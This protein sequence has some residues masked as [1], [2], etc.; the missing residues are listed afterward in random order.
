MT[1]AAGSQNIN[2]G[3]GN[4]TISGD[5]GSDVLDG[6]SGTN[7]VTYSFEPST[8]PVGIDLTA[9]TATAPDGTST[10]NN[11]QN[12]V[13]G[14]GDDTLRGT[15]G[16][17]T[18]QGGDG[19]DTI[20]GLGG[21]DTIDGQG[22]TNTV[23]YADEP[24][25]PG[26]TVDLS[27]GTA[28]T[29][30]GGTD[31]LSN[32]E[33]IRGGPA[34]DT[35]KMPATGTA[36]VDMG[37]GTNTLDFSAQAAGAKFNYSTPTTVVV[38]GQTF[39]DVEKLIGT[40]GDDTINGDSGNQDIN[41]GPGDDTI[42]GGG[43]SDTLDG[44]TGTN[45]VSFAF[46]FTSVVLDLGSG[47]SA[48]N[49]GIC[50]LANF[51]N[52]I[53]GAGD[54]L[55]QG[56]AGANTLDGG[57]GNDTIQG[58]GGGDTINGQGGSDTV[59]Y[60]DEPAG[61]GVVVDLAAGTAN[62][63]DGATDKL[64]NVE[65]ILGGP[66]DDTVKMAASGNAGVD[67][68]GGTNTLDFTA[69]RSGSTFDFT[70]PTT[71]TIGSQTFPN[72]QKL[73]GSSAN[74]TF[75][76]A[77][78]TDPLDGGGGVN[79]L[80]YASLA[81]GQDVTVDLQAGTALTPLGQTSITNFQNATGGGGNDELLGTVG[82][83][84]LIGG[85]GD[86]TLDGRA[87][88][89]YLDGGT[90]NDTLR[91]G[92]GKD[93]ILGGAGNDTVT[94]DDRSAPVTI[95]LDAQPDSGESGE[96]DL[97][98]GVENAIGGSGDDTIVGNAGNNDLQGGDGNDTLIGGLGDDTLD[99][100]AGND[101]ASYADRGDND[102]VTVDLA[103]G[104]GGERG[105]HDQLVSIEGAIGGDAADTLNGGPGNDTLDGGA[106]DDTITGG[107]GNDTI[108][109]GAGN[110]FIDGGP[111]ADTVTGG[112]GDDVVEAA[113]GTADTVDCGDGKDVV[114]ADT[115]DIISNCETIHLPQGSLGGAPPPVLPTDADGDGYSPPQDCN[116]HNPN[117]HPG[118]YDIPGDG[119]DQNCDGHD[120]QFPPISA[121]LKARFSSARHGW[122]RVR[123]LSVKHAAANTDIEVSC[124]SSHFNACP[125]RDE[126]QVLAHQTPFYSLR[127][128]FG[129]VPVRPGTK[130]VLKLVQPGAIGRIYTYLFRQGSFPKLSLLCQA[131][132]KPV[133]RC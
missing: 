12:A 129:D 92:T 109:G 26:V 91:G 102:P 9:G 28:K 38:G 25:G 42:S 101:I 14:A 8:N 49:D 97:I 35:V 52:A 110:D 39:P 20:Q 40:S 22:G 29:P 60:A 34:D 95:K 74:D 33:K 130:F 124:R 78:T 88:D 15:S 64:S 50:S 19:N 82:A 117:I 66:A 41:G 113:D 108:D 55:L 69:Q 98:A 107:A 7:T 2:G 46:E 127:A 16:A 72:V 6:G 65:T 18:L 86:D 24:A 89:D 21:G 120:A 51:Q 106:G 10:L 76:A 58:F 121:A 111:G 104:T 13:G 75:D 31:Q 85:G 131:P 62:T 47:L 99:G 116:D 30:D 80:S 37:A 56:T 115:I 48:S 57:P 71:F 77:D 83:N 17:N 11:F 79:T 94:Y 119:I 96:D 90:G 100:G 63:P 93:F 70:G 133:T 68:G 81:G 36:D 103:A 128:L 114:D 67:M 87:G 5:G 118:A 105:E 4:D 53:G 1:G 45:T 126:V 123:Q 125:F 122:T 132:G 73:I 32:I 61:Q 112:S 84:T 54:D 23:T 44:G 3:P 59:T 43:G 27:A